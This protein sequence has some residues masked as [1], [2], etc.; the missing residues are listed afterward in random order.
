MHYFLQQIISTTKGILLMRLFAMME[1]QRLGPV[2]RIHP[3]IQVDW[4]GM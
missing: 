3:I 1:A 2:T 4:A